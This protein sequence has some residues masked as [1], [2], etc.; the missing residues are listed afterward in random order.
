MKNIIFRKGI[1]TFMKSISGEI[2]L[3]LAEQGVISKDDADRCRYGLYVFLTSIFELASI[4]AVSIF[5]GNFLQTLIFFAAFIPIRM[6]AG[7]YH[8][9]TKLRCFITSIG[10][11]IIFSVFM[12]YI[13]ADNISLIILV[14]EFA[15]SSIMIFAYSPIIHKNKHINIKEF[16]AYRKI[17]IGIFVSELLIISVLYILIEN[18]E[19]VM[20][21]VLGQF[22]ETSSMIAAKIKE[23][24]C[25]N[26]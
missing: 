13:Y 4:L 6:Y 15:F 12:R 5:V 19:Y 10:V 20:S 25:D 24:I 21:A 2:A 8:A 16:K 7:G 26:K 17:S 18:K 14:T 3:L 23:R 11:Y 1:V 22:A 9:D